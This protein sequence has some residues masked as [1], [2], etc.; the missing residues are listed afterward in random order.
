MENFFGY[1]FP[2]IESPNISE[3]NVLGLEDNSSLFSSGV[4]NGTTYFLS[5][6]TADLMRKLK[7][8]EVCLEFWIEAIDHNTP[9][10]NNKLYP[11]DV[12]Q[13][14]LE[15]PSFQRQLQLGGVPGR[16]CPFIS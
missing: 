3:L 16:V 6:L 8:G 4:K 10:A 13:R 14:G 9:T 15:S 2:L 1:D 5:G 12:F 11:A 7:N